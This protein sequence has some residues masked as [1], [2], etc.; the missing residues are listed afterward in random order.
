L[1]LAGHS[2][3]DGV[4]IG[5]GFKVSQSV[6][7]IVSL[8]VITHDFTD[9]LN[10]VT[11]MLNHHNPVQRTRHLL[12][13]DAAAPLLGILSTHFFEPS[14]EFLVLYMG[15]FAGFLLYIGAS[16]ILPEAHSKDS[17]PLTIFMTLI[18]TLLS[19]ALS[20]LL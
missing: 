3:M 10:S 18:G 13:L 2:F 14:R 11:V 15:F 12:I 1:A 20:R 19:F 8:A 16:D 9:G 17:S 5:L 4:A 7:I 6:G